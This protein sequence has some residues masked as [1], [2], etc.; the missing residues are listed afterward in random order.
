[1]AKQLDF[2]KA[3]KQFLTITFIDGQ[4]VL[5]KHPTKRIMD[6]L[7]SLGD[8]FKNTESEESDDSIENIFSACAEILSNNVGSK[9]ITVE[10]LSDVLDFEDLIIFFNTYMDFVGELSDI[11]N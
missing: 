1:M 7:I 9:K 6:S 8:E 10:Y 5:V 4:V 3:K 2:T 11:K